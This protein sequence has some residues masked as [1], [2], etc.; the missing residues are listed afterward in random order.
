MTGLRAGRQGQYLDQLQLETSA[1]RASPPYGGQGGE[2]FRLTLDGGAAIGGLLVGSSARGFLRRLGGCLSVPHASERRRDAAAAAAAP[3]LGFV[4][5]HQ[6]RLRKNVQAVAMLAAALGAALLLAGGYLLADT[7]LGPAPT[8]SLALIGPG[9]GLK[10]HYVELRCPWPPKP[11]GRRWVEE[12]PF[13]IRSEKKFVACTVEEEE[14]GLEGLLTYR[15]AGKTTYVLVKLPVVPGAP[16][17]EKAAD[18]TVAV[19][20]MLRSVGRA[21][22]PQ[23]VST[24]ISNHL[25]GMQ[26]VG[27]DNLQYLDATFSPLLLLA[28]GAAMLGGLVWGLCTLRALR[29]GR[30]PV[31]SRTPA[32]PARV[33][34]RPCGCR[35]PRVEA[36]R[37]TVASGAGHVGVCAVRRRR[38]RQRRGSGPGG[39]RT[40]GG[41]RPTAGHGWGT[42]LARGR[43]GAGGGR[44][45]RP[46]WTG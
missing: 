19:R 15:L 28:G 14:Q 43:V 33:H 6:A 29:A 16:P 37:L 5:H 20:G 26:E 10:H 12:Y 45:R 13:N 40:R 46:T 34:R 7:A 11:V 21:E 35:R 3:A 8:T 9:G 30:D 1:G 2:P 32:A 42:C 4:R 31:R 41:A 22:V 23:H 18:G 24:D 36:A 25:S 27:V 38:G 17:P 39:A 44:R